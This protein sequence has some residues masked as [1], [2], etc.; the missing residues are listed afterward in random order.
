[1][2]KK[3]VKKLELSKETV[4]RLENLVSVRGGT[5]SGVSCDVEYPCEDQ[6]PTGAQ[7]TCAG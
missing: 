2:K 3:T 6:F 7:A 5:M 4:Q 1:M